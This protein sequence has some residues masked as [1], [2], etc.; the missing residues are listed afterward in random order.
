MKLVKILSA[1]IVSCVS[2]VAI[3]SAQPHA[4]GMKT[5]NVSF[6]GDT[7]SI[8]FPL[9]VETVWKTWLGRHRHDIMTIKKG[10]TRITLPYPATKVSLMSPNGDDVCVMQ[11]TNPNTL[12]IANHGSYM[13]CKF[14]H[15]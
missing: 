9:R 2:F 15:V 11:Q 7:G 8:A 4:F 3:A 12:Y 13:S 1:A 14:Q 6:A 5:Y 10:Q